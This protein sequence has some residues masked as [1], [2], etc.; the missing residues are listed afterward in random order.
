MESYI[1]PLAILTG[2]LA[3][4]HWLNSHIREREVNPSGL[5]L[6]PGP[7]GLPVIGNLFDLP[8]FKPWL[9]YDNW[10]KVYGD[11]IY[12]NILGQGILIL[13]S[14]EKIHD[15]FEKRSSN[16]SDRIP[17]TMLVDIMG[18]DLAMSTH[19]Y[20]SWWR[21]H[22]R[23]FHDH[24]N[25]SAIKRYHQTQL[26]GA[27]TFLRNL[28]RSPSDHLMDHIRLAFASTIT[29]AA[30]GIK[31]K[32][33]EDE[34]VKLAEEALKGVS[35]AAVPGAFLVDIFPIMKYIPAWFPGANWR[36]KGDRW[37]AINDRVVNEP[38]D[39][40]KQQVK[41][42]KAVP[43]IA[44]R[45]I[46]SL[47]E[48]MTH[49]Q[50]EEELIARHTCASAYLAGAD[51][52][53]S[54][55]QTFFLA[56]SMYPEHQKKAQ[57]EL[58]SVLNGRLP[59]FGDRPFLP[60]INAIVKET[61]RWQPVTPMGFGHAASEADEYN[62]YYIPKGTLV[63]GST[64][65]IMRD[66]E[67]YDRPDEFNPERYLKD[68]KIN[69]AVRDP[70]VAAFGYGRRICPGRHFS[71]ESLFSII[72]H[73]LAVYDIRPGLDENGNEAKIVPDYTSGLFSYPAAFPA[74]VIP[75]SKAAEDLIV[76]TELAD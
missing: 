14:L 10:F 11:M 33:W 24:F 70:S 73:T 29:E 72:A 26:T 54:A 49:E 55:V 6:P 7:K 27:R 3:V 65:G 42:G 17:L 71:D 30:Y 18:W 60:H 46:E 43:S 69:P 23:A 47:P 31:I 64:W 9:V 16:Y 15:I 1:Q 36:R 5:P 48:N 40:V 59:E 51:T 57:A 56:M 44:Q 37:A 66:P 67:A 68:G 63:M 53:V 39:F 34:Y 74:R 76:S 38:F 8:I 12:L 20:G 75:R 61:M 62:G 22:R 28:L 35:E 41:E 2:C 50:K 58:D 13:G 25:P 32:T 4:V 52:T 21:R 45:F 19:R